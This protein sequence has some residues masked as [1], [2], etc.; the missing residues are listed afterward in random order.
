MK[1][2][3]SLLAFAALLPVAALLIGCGSEAAKS[4]ADDRVPVLV[5]TVGRT[6]MNRVR[7]FSGTVEGK[8]QAA[9][10]ARIP[11]I[12]SKIHPNEGDRIRVG[13]PLISFEESGPNSA[14]RQ[15]RAVAED[16][17]RTYEKYERLFEQGA[18]SEKE[19]D[20]VQTAYEVAQ[21]DFD[22]ARDRTTLRAPISGVVTEITA[23]VGR[24]PGVGESLATIAAIDTARLVIDVAVYE[25][26]EFKRGQTAIIR[27]EQDTTVRLEGWVDEVSSSANPES[28]TVRVELLAPNP[29][30]RLLP[31][32]F[33][34]AEI[35][36]E[37]KEQ[38]VAIPR[39]AL[40][41]RESGL[42]VF[43]VTDS[44]VRLIPI[45]TGIE[46]GATVEVTSGVT[47]GESIVI[48]G[49]HNLQNGTVVNPVPDSVTHR[50]TGVS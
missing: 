24:Q 45:T 12:V 39:D 47:A 13:E 15:A 28:R 37:S 3:H 20:A 21:A 43:V 33:V 30:H 46:S 10:T 42:A 5:T 44:T 8:R 1:R 41:Y 4:G 23:R 2:A 50:P 34:R 40:V 19:R 35:Q 32:M 22:A 27:S 38:V 49:Q 17:K 26:R 14:V 11:E 29:D 18:V 48:L 36:L 7:A 25:S 6:D 9:L 31:G 16:A